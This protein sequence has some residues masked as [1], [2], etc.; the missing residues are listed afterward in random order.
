MRLT[1]MHLAGAEASLRERHPNALD[2][3]EERTPEV[4][5]VLAHLRHASLESGMMFFKNVI[6]VC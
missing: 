2:E 6:N 3:E 5:E 4:V 1:L